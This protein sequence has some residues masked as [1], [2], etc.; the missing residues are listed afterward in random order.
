MSLNSGTTATS[1]DTVMHVVSNQPQTLPIIHHQQSSSSV[2]RINSHQQE[3]RNIQQQ[4]QQQLQ[5]SQQSQ[6]TTNNA[7]TSIPQEIAI[8]S[9]SDLISFINPN[10]FDQGKFRLDSYF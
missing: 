7:Q 5:Q 10:A 2:V 3:T 8:M 9:E 4:Q 1:T 6:S